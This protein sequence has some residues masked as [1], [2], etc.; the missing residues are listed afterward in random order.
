MA[1]TVAYLRATTGSISG[2]GFARAKIIESL[3]IVAMSAS[4]RMFGALTPMNTSAPTSASGIVP[5]KLLGL[6]LSMNHCCI[7]SSDFIELWI[8]PW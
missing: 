5:I 3:A 6:L 7:E 2:S 1:T 4:L 8:T